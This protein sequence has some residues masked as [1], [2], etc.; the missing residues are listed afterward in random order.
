MV[1]QVLSSG[2][3]LLLAVLVA[4]QTDPTTFGA[5]SVALIVH[6]LLLG[7]MRAAVGDVVLLRC[8]ADLSAARREASRGLFLALVTGM[9]AGVGLLAVGSSIGGQVGG[10]LMVA[11]VAAPVV[12][13]QDVLRY[14]AYGRARVDDTILLDGVWLGVQ[15]VV[16]AMLLQS[17]RATPTTLI[18][19]WVVG[20]AAGAAVGA[21]RGRVRP[22]ALAIG[23]WLAEERAR[24]GGFV[25]D[26]LVSNGLWQASFLVVGVVLSLGQ[27]AGLRVALVAVSPLANLLGGVRALALAHLAGLAAHPAQTRQ[28]AVVV[29]LGLA[30]AAAA[31]GAALVVM[32][33]TWGAELF[34]ASWSEAS[35]VVAIIAVAE[36]IRLPTFAPIDLIKVL[37]EPVDL[38][39][40]RLAGGLVVAAGMMGGAMV[41]GPRGAALGTVVGYSWSQFVWWRRA[42]IVSRRAA[43]TV[44]SVTL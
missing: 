24:A 26:Y 36:V 25:S 44:A 12:Y 15:V 9:A 1:D 35:T 28:R 10:Y 39:R 30:G 13:A 23:R 31:Y 20:A 5:V 42:S 19:A 17:S 7:V 33:D 6:G 43:A 11:A 14:V 37:G 29:A 18:L 34:G 41:A 32:P 21:V 22:R 4:R 38:V 27:L 3:Q 8:R 2:A 40:T 16:S